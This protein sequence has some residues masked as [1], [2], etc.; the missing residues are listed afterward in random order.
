VTDFLTELLAGDALRYLLIGDLLVLLVV[1]GVMWRA[2][3]PHVLPELSLMAGLYGAV[4]SVFVAGVGVN[5]LSPIPTTP[6][7]KVSA[8][9]LTGL[10]VAILWVASRSLHIRR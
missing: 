8:V 4:L 9:L 6:G 1:G 7:A 10:V 2:Y 3:R 5:L